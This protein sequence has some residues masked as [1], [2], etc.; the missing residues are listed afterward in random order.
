MLDPKMQTEL[1]AQI[2]EELYSSYLYLAMA[3]H[4]S[5]AGLGGFAHRLR[6]QSVEEGAHA[7]KIFDYIHGQGGTVSLQAIKE[8][9]AKFGSRVQVFEQVLAHEQDITGLINGLVDSAKQLNDH[10]TQVFL[11]WFVTEQVE[12]EGS[13]AGIL[14]KVKMVGDDGPGLLALDRELHSRTSAG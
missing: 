10:A 4:F 7:M 5:T 3:A 9:K 1:N 6:A 2:N 13:A 11:Q 12:E 8:P 14:Q